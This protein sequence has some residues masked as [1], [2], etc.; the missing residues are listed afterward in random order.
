M[1]LQERAGV[2]GGVVGVGAEKRDLRPVAPR[3]RGEQ[4]ELAATGPA[5]RGPGVDDDRV[6]AERA[7]PRRQERPGAQELVCL[8]LER[9][10]RDRG[11]WGRRCASRWVRLG[12]TGEG[13]ADV[14]DQR[15]AAGPPEHADVAVPKELA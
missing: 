12:R 5:P 13:R 1:L 15:R 4:R 11:S 3:R 7:D 9:R 2:A 14:P 6:A 10:Q 8:G